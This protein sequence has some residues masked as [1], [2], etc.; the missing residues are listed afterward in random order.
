M[1]KI[2]MM[3]EF[4]LRSEKKDLTLPWSCAIQM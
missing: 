3:V 1:G 4:Q 2:M